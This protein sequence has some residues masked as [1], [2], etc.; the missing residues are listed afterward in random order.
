MRLIALQD[1]HHNL[2]IIAVLR[3]LR[4]DEIHSFTHEC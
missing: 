4:V 3:D 2:E 1:P